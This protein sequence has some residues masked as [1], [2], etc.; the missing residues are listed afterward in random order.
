MTWPQGL[1]LVIP[2]APDPLGSR[3]SG[4]A[5]SLPGHSPCFWHRWRTSAGSV[6]AR[7]Y[8]CAEGGQESAC[9][10]S[11]SE[12]L[13]GRWPPA[14]CVRCC[15]RAPPSAGTTAVPTLGGTGCAR[16]TFWLIRMRPLNQAALGLT[17]T[18]LLFEANMNIFNTQPFPEMSDVARG[19]G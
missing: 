4:T 13:P 8:A 6:R 3:C 12:L 5:C 10:F 7:A 15:A 11:R 16:G 1:L 9:P 14:R 17:E 2:A 19:P 18:V